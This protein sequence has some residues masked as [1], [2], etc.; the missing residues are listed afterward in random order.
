MPRR[1]KFGG[2]CSRSIRVRFVAEF[3]PAARS[4]AKPSH[5]ENAET[6]LTFRGS[7]PRC[8]APPRE[9]R[10]EFGTSESAGPKRALRSE[11][12]RQR[13]AGARRDG[14]VVAGI[15]TH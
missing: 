10:I 7:A 1:E 13:D 8:S 5:A 14:E 11:N 6:E 9:P 3:D 2:N 4:E 15:P 12:R